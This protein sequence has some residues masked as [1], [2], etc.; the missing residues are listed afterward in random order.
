MYMGVVNKG[1]GGEGVSCLCRIKKNIYIDFCLAVSEELLNTSRPPFV[2][3]H[4][5]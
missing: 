4:Y 3:I 5:I 1:G 2:Y